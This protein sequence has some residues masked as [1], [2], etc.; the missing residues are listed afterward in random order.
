[1]SLE[2]GSILRPTLQAWCARSL[3]V[4]LYISLPFT[5][6]VFLRHSTPVHEGLCSFG[7][8]YIHCIGDDYCMKADVSGEETQHQQFFGLLLI[9]VHAIMI[10]AVIFQGYLTLQ[11]QRVMVHFLL[12]VLT[13]YVYG[14]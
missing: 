2:V 5:R 10:M 9:L 3:S 12:D 4:C 6:L 14:T 7:N 13:D 1:M 11:V 8:P